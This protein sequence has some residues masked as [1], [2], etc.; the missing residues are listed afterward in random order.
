VVQPITASSRKFNQIT[1]SN[2]DLKTIPI[3]K[4]IHMKP[5]WRKIRKIPD[6]KLKSSTVPSKKSS[7]ST[8]TAG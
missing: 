2:S 1:S 6:K 3:P 8:I 5:I 7:M 4:P